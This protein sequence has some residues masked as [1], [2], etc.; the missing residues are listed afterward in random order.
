MTKFDMRL[1]TVSQED[2]HT[3]LCVIAAADGQER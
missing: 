3:L 1:V 2:G